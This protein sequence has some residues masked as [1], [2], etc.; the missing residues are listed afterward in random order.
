MNNH[1][2]V[3]T[4]IAGCFFNETIINLEDQV[5]LNRPGGEVLYAAAGFNLLQKNAGLVS[6]ISNDESIEWINEF[7]NFPINFLGINKASVHFD[8]KRFYANKKTGEVETANPQKHF[9]KIGVSLP[10]YLLGYSSPQS[11]IDKRNSPT[12]SSLKPTNIPEIFLQAHNLILCP[13]DYYTHSLIPPYFRSK[14]DGNVILCASNGYMHPSFW[15]EIPALIRGSAAFLTT[16][17]QI[18]NLFLGK[19]DDIWDMTAYLANCGV[20]IIS[21][22]GKERSAF[23]YD[24]SSKNKIFI[25][26]FPSKAID[27]IG[28]YATFCGGFGAGFTTHFDP[29]RAGLMGVVT[30][31]INI[32]GS[33]PLHTFRALPELANAR[34]EA[35]KSMITI[36]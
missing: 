32:E 29:I 35:L 25:P 24:G 30:A 26:F 3:N 2:A 19:T 5:F 21:V 17:H 4:I 1:L 20:E 6:T 13:I 12:F 28:T 31:S 27:L 18:R 36:V 8:Q 22:F 23:I 7:G 16:E 15:Y 14:T 9:F 11:G 10:K 34:L 33:T